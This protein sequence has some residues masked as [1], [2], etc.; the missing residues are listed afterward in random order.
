MVRLAFIGR[1]I[2][3]GTI[4]K[5]GFLGSADEILGRRRPY[6]VKERRWSESEVWKPHNP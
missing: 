2:T 3:V 4:E 1:S 5:A 6:G